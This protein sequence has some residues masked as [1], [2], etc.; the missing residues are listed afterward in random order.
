MKNIYQVMFVTIGFLSVLFSDVLA[1]KPEVIKFTTAKVKTGDDIMWKNPLMDDSDWKTVKTSLCF[2]KQ[3]FAN[4][5]GYIWY[6]IHFFM[7]ALLLNNAVDKDRII[8]NLAIPFHIA[9][10][11]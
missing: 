1:Q 8:L 7:P 4:Y 5:D 11:M 10:Q 6:R 2:E 3:G 9:Q